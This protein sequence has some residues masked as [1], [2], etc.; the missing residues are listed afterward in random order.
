M[1]VLLLIIITSYFIVWVVYF[2]YNGG[3]GKVTYVSLFV[4]CTVFACWVVA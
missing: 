3:S 1:T 4:K 2:M